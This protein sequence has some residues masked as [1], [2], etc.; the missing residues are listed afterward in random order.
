MSNKINRDSWNNFSHHYQKNLRI[1]LEDIHYGPYGPGEKSL[2]ILGS[3]KGLKI[4]D[5]GCGG[6]QNSIVLKKC[7]AMSVIGL[8][9]SEEQLIYAKKLIQSHTITD[10]KYIQGDMEDLSIFENESFDMVFSSHA[11]TYASNIKNVFFEV[12][13]VLRK[14]GRLVFCVVHPMVFPVWEVFEEQ[15]LEKVQ[16]YFSDKREK[17]DWVYDDGKEKAP[18]ESSYH[19]FETLINGLLETGFII[20]RVIEPKGYTLEEV[21]KLQ[22][23][24]PYQDADRINENFIRVNQNIPFS[25]IISVRKNASN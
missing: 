23:R 22:D 20:E 18:F 11:M 7:G 13:R 14:P 9:Q 2:K 10:V 21:K 25:L 1:S 12:F 15:A 5:L 16:S 8:D 17:W 4:L 24:V 19:R 3:V 6:G